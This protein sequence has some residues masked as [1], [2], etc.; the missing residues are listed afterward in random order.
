MLEI[1]TPINSFKKKMNQL[2]FMLTVRHSFAERDWNQETLEVAAVPAAERP[3]ERRTSTRSAGR[4]RSP[5][6]HQRKNRRSRDNTFLLPRLG[7]SRRRS[8][9]PPRSRAPVPS[10]APVPQANFSGCSKNSGN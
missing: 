10:P 9:S 7:T 6:S 2:Q 3:T 5:Q 8:I 4:L 1:T